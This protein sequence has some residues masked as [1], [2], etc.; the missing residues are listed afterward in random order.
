MNYN[1]VD[2]LVEVYHSIVSEDEIIHELLQ[3]AYIVI[4]R[5][6]SDYL[7]CSTVCLFMVSKNNLIT[8]M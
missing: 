4:L 5:P 8:C 7:R 1:H 6:L 2:L 3:L